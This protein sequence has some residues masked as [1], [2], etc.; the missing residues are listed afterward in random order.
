MPSLKC[1]PHTSN[2]EKQ[3]GLPMAVAQVLSQ[4]LAQNL[5]IQWE[6]SSRKPSMYIDLL[7]FMCYSV[8]IMHVRSIKK[9]F[10]FLSHNTLTVVYLLPLNNDKMNN[11]RWFLI[12]VGW[13]N[14]PFKVHKIVFL[15][16]WSALSHT[17]ECW[18]GWWWILT[19]WILT[20]WV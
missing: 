1:F 13:R 8:C 5:G 14:V 18:G 7:T 17:A 15:R 3:Y 6:P 12:C 10:S 19:L 4:S 9:Y 16:A 11:L 2:S 20:S